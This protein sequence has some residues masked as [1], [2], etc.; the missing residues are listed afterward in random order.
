METITD[1]IQKTSTFDILLRDVL[2]P[3]KPE[4]QNAIGSARCYWDTL[5]LAKQR[6]IYWQ[7]REDKRHGIAIK[8]NP[9]FAIEDCTPVPTNWNGRQGINEKMKSEKMVSAKYKPSAKY[10]VYTLT[11]AQLF[12]MTDIKPLNY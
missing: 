6:Q 7:L 12:E 3:I 4:Y 9:R 11:E 2:Q 8:D 10:G 5:T 1:V